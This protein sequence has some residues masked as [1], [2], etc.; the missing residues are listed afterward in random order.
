MMQISIKLQADREYAVECGL[1]EDTHK[2]IVEYLV[3]VLKKGTELRKIEPGFLLQFPL[4]D[5][6]PVFPK[7]AKPRRH[8]QFGVVGLAKNILYVTLGEGRCLQMDECGMVIGTVLNAD[9]VRSIQRVPA[10]RLGRPLEP[11]II[12]SICIDDNTVYQRQADQKET[13]KIHDPD[14]EQRLRLKLLG[15]TAQVSSNSLQT[16]TVFLARLSPHTTASS[17]R[18]LFTRFGTVTDCRV[19]PDKRIAF[20]SMSRVEECDE[21][22]RR[23]NGVVIDDCRVRVDYAHSAVDQWERRRFGQSKFDDRL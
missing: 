15:D 5:N 2:E 13:G 3:G 9:V 22:V 18:L 20:V 21:A 17:L 6:P 7:P 11:V 1:F 16:R 14:R 4:L 10:D 19:N 12:T 8:L 23:M